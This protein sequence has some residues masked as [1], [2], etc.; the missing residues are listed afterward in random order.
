M[1]I[2]TNTNNN[3][4]EQ[5]SMI[6]DMIHYY[7]KNIL[8]YQ[9]NME[10][11]IKILGR[12]HIEPENPIGSSPSSS[13]SSSSSSS[14]R[15][16]RVNDTHSTRR[17]PTQR[18]T[19]TSS[20]NMNNRSTNTNNNNNNNR[21]PSSRSSNVFNRYLRRNNNIDN[22]IYRSF[23]TFI[24]LSTTQNREQDHLLT[25]SQI[26]TATETISYTNDLDET[27]C[28]ISFEDFTIDENIIKIKN[29]GHYFKK[30]SL[31]NWLKR[32]SHCPV[33]RYNLRDHLE[34]NQTSPEEPLIDETYQ[35]EPVRDEEEHARTPESYRSEISTF[36]ESII[37]N[38]DNEL[39]TSFDFSNN[40]FI[41]EYSIDLFNN[42]PDVD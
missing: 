24:P 10:N 20:N 8:E 34:E 23:Y 22:D 37:R 32:S 39:L 14:Q 25:E 5:Q 18:T 31:L 4:V 40:Q 35:E 9:H 38:I 36:L 28:P 17:N 42:S 12:E 13:S 2:R 21:N 16:N 41:A 19:S 27:K 3:L 29:C 6:S 15:L 33:C 11:I 26:Q 1:S 30:N 7:N